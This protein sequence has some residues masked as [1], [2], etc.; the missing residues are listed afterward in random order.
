MK[1]SES[2]EYNQISED[3]R[4]RDNFTWQLPSV[5]LVIGSALIVTAFGLDIDLRYLN[6]VRIILLGLGALLSFSLTW[7]LIQNLWYQVGSSQALIN[8]QNNE[9][10]SGQKLKNKSHRTIRFQ[11]S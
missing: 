3:W 1:D 5:I 11:K 8:L 6:T 4:H 10:I 7:A 9:G 2:T